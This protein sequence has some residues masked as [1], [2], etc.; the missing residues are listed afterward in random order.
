[1][2]H[3]PSSLLSD[4]ESAMQFPAADTVFAVSEQPQCRHPLGKRDRRILKNSLQF[5]RELPPTLMTLPALLAFNPVM[6]V[7]GQT[8]RTLHAIRPAHSGESIN[9]HLLIAKVLNSL[10]K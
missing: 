2:Q 1:M 10:L 9:T 3:E 6:T 7:L 4:T 8:G 5:D